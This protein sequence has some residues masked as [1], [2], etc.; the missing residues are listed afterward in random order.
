MQ[1]YKDNLK[2]ELEGRLALLADKIEEKGR[3]ITRLQID[4]YMRNRNITA[5]SPKYSPDELAILFNYYQEMI[6]K[7]NERALLIK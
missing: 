3:N 2:N 1:E 5:V 7:I 4:S 6:E